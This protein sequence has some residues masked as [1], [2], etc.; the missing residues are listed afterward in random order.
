MTQFF[1][2]SSKIQII[3]PQILKHSSSI[4]VWVNKNFVLVIITFEAG[5][6]VLHFSVVEEKLEAEKHISPLP[7]L[8]KTLF[9]DGSHAHLSLMVDVVEV[10]SDAWFGALALDVCSGASG[11]GVAGRQAAKSGQSS[12][13][14]RRCPQ[15]RQ[16]DG[17]G[18]GERVCPGRTTKRKDETGTCVFTGKIQ[19]SPSC[20]CL[21]LTV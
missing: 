1:K 15:Q 10:L 14:E 12:A 5:D 6:K 8:W 9:C 2:Y 7:R 21:Q 18:P 17:A 13:A 3:I 20:C 19:A 16:H 11:G 4:C